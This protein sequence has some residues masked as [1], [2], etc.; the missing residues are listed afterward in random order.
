MQDRQLAFNILNKIERDKAYSNLTLDSC[1]SKN[2]GEVYSSAFVTALVYGVT[3]RLIT[4][5]YILSQYLTKPLKKLKPEVL[6]ALRLGAYQL[7]FM[8][9]VP[10]SAA[11]NESVKLV[12]KNGCAY[13]S[14]LVN[15]V[16]RRVS[17]NE[18][19]F[20][21]IDK[22]DELLSVKYSCPV[23]L[24]NSFIADYG[25][26]DTEKIL[27][28]SLGRPNTFARVN[29]LKT[30]TEE[31]LERLR[32]EGITAEKADGFENCIRF[33]SS[34]SFDS[35]KSFSEGL[36]HVQDLSSAQC[37]RLLDVS[38][39]MTVVD[40]CAAPGGKSFT[41]AQI[42]NNKG[43]IISFD[44]YESRVKL[45]DDNARRLGIDIITAC[46]HDSSKT[47]SSLTECAD[48]VL[49]DV[50]CSCLGTIGRK[51]EI[52]YKDLAFIDKLSQLQY[53]ILL[54]SSR[55]LKHGGLLVY[56]TCS[57]SKRENEDVADRFLL[58]NPE[59]EKACEYRTFM[60]HKDGTDGFFTAGFRRK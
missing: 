8:D 11:V 52:R 58:N 38:E 39:G 44:L 43:R 49:C 33:D 7:K 10:D 29:T 32:Q 28:H 5:D 59:F 18:I 50:P 4:L 26:E 16:L 1:L 35:C 53:N 48:R 54:S 23:S 6:T 21:K 46:A 12:K 31:L 15:S 40:A 56:S 37:V 2:E 20:S 9:S 13:A 42:M 57:L 3:E 14:G 36:F 17:E 55:Y 41:A 45:I 22:T 51:P 30:N 19:D 25:I 27:E 34:F 60:P 47:D 24:V